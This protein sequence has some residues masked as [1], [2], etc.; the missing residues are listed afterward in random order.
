LSRNVLDKV[1][2]QVAGQ[3]RS[4]EGDI[5]GEKEVRAALIEQADFFRR[6][7]ELINLC[8]PVWRPYAVALALA[9][10]EELD[11]ADLAAEKLAT[12]ALGPLEK[13]RKQL[14]PAGTKQ[15]KSGDKVHKE[16][17]AAA[18]ATS[19][20]IDEE[21]S[22]ASNKAGSKQKSESK[23]AAV[24]TKGKD[25]DM[26]VPK[27]KSPD[28]AKEEGKEAV[29]LSGTVLSGGGAA[30]AGTG[31][32]GSALR[33]SKLPGVAATPE[34]PKR[35][36]TVAPP[37]S[38]TGASSVE[39]KER[40]VSGGGSAGSGGAGSDGGSSGSNKVATA[41]A[42]G[43]TL[44]DFQRVHAP[45]KE[46][47]LLALLK[48]IGDL[49]LDSA[50]SSRVV[51]DVKLPQILSHPVTL[52]LMKDVLAK[53]LSP[54]NIALWIDIQRYRSLEN[55]SVRKA[56][57][58]EIC[59]TF[60]VSGAKFEV[61]LSSFMRD[62]VRTQ[63]NKGVHALDLFDEVEREIYRL[64]VT[65][66]TEPLV[67]SNMFKLAALVLQHPAY[68]LKSASLVNNVRGEVGGNV[69]S[70]IGS[71][72]LLAPAAAVQQQAAMGGN[73]QGLSA[74]IAQ[75]RGNSMGVGTPTG[76]RGIPGGGGVGRALAPS[77]TNAAPATR[78]SAMMWPANSGG[79]GAARAQGS[80]SGTPRGSPNASPV[81][82]DRE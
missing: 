8:R 55:A 67:Q 17:S 75:G 14:A 52:E 4:L 3:V 30:Q 50:P 7:L 80:N 58:D 46:K 24:L 13:E 9:D 72:A 78:P 12:A 62:Y 42:H 64:M 81:P 34:Q 53:N 61:N 33:P 22:G 69:A 57:A 23:E 44:S 51:A 18:G 63:V 29:E 66:N 56:V 48:E 41:V 77:P 45:K 40:V 49:R 60:I 15:Q 38:A 70:T 79:A 73:S 82:F 21:K 10:P 36:V 6:S 76:S 26:L 27:A 54:E 31:H 11:A 74:G 19:G 1:L 35:K 43:S 71:Q 39:E 16:K 2:S 37:V 65:N 20:K 32:E 59:Q 5:E 25:K 47:Q 28:P 68:K